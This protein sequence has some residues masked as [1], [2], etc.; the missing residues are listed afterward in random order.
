[1]PQ[2]A[3]L[4]AA[5]TNPPKEIR[6]QRAEQKIQKVFKSEKRKEK[7]TDEKQHVRSAL[8]RAEI[9]QY[10]GNQY[11]DKKVYGQYGQEKALRSGTFGYAR[12][13]DF[14]RSKK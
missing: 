1:M 12:I 10:R 5:S 9:V 13:C 11:E 2:E 4:T 8:A 14:T 6:E 7:S 3:P